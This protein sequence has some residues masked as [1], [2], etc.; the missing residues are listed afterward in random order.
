MN[1]INTTAGMAESLYFIYRVIHISERCVITK[2]C[3]EL[4]GQNQALNYSQPV[5]RGR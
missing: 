1:S 4:Q 3:Q 5:F 2:K